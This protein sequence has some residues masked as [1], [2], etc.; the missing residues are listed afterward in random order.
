MTQ[1]RSGGAAPWIHA[2]SSL[3]VGA[4]AILML[5]VNWFDATTAGSVAGAVALVGLIREAEHGDVSRRR[6]L[7]LTGLIMG[8]GSASVAQLLPGLLGFLAL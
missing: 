2:V 7:H 3:V 8:V 5:G 1:V 6:S 4:A